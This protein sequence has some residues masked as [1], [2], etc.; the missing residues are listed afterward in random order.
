MIQK[1]VMWQN[2][3]HKYSKPTT[4][5]SYCHL[6]RYLSTTTVASSDRDVASPNPLDQKLNIGKALKKSFERESFTNL[7]QQSVECLQGVGPKHAEELKA[8]NLKTIQQLAEYKFFH[9]ARS[10]TTLAL[11]EMEGGRL[12]GTVMNVNKGVDKEYEKMSLNEM[13]QQPVHALQGISPKAGETLASL[14]VTTVKDLA[15]FKYCLLAESFTVL[16]KFEDSE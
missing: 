8:L 14:G 11:V 4:A 9:L 16:A 5:G 15:S 1:V 13:I 7:S 2:V 12:E 6:Q 10:M 3:I